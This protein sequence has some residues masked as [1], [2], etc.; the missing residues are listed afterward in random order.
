[1]RK[2]GIGILTLLLLLCV[3]AT[4]ALAQEASETN[5]DNGN[6]CAPGDSNCTGNP[7]A[8]SEDGTPGWSEDGMPGWSQPSGST[9][10]SVAALIGAI[11]RLPFVPTPPV[12]LPVRL[13]D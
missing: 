13:D 12:I 6:S 4:P 11:V 5:P 1:M 7:G 3:A 8:W 2:A 9:T 10:N